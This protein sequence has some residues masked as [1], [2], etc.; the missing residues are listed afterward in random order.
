ML[1]TTM[2]CERCSEFVAGSWEGHEAHMAHYHKDDVGCHK[3]DKFWTSNPQEWDWH[4]KRCGT[5]SPVIIMTERE[6][7]DQRK[8]RLALR[9]EEKLGK[10]F[11]I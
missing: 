2:K 8:K 9:M 6:S 5:D 1:P 3:C 7:S 11:F 10:E 4:V